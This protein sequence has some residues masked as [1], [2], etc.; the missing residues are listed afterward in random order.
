MKVK[1]LKLLSVAAAILTLLAAG[2][3][4][5]ASLGWLYQ[6]KTPKCLTK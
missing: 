3:T 1:S 6:P 5:S 4:S 2:I